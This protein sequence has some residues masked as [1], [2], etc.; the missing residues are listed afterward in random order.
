MKWWQEPE[1]NRRHKDF[2]S[3][4]LPT[5]L[6][7][8]PFIYKHLWCKCR[9]QFDVVLVVVLVLPHETA[10][11]QKHCSKCHTSS[12]SSVT[13]LESLRP[14]QAQNSRPVGAQ[15]R[16]LRTVDRHGRKHR[17]ENCAP[18]AHGRRRG[19]TGADGSR[20]GQG[21]EQ[22]QGQA[23]GQCFKPDTQTHPQLG[24]IFPAISHPLRS[25]KK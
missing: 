20:S 3:S 7:C 6:S 14:A 16:F 25:V 23:G 22:A 12:T 17:Q 15:R 1:L 18:D 13:I 10:S 24:G 9:C 2:Q 4:A 11:S 8:Q 5:E 21:D 19:K